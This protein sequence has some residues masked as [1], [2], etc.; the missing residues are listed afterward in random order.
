MVILQIV[1]FLVLRKEDVLKYYT[2]CTLDWSSWKNATFINTES[3]KEKVVTKMNT[4]ISYTVSNTTYITKYT[5]MNK[6][7]AIHCVLLPA[8]KNTAM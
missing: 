6:S 5:V 3:V 8:G 2:E 4:N 1:S 7:K